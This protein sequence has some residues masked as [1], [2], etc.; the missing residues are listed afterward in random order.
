[1]N[2]EEE[3][4]NAL[5]GAILHVLPNC[6]S[7]LLFHQELMKKGIILTLSEDDQEVV[8]KNRYK[9]FL[10]HDGKGGPISSRELGAEFM[11]SSIVEKIEENVQA[12]KDREAIEKCKKAYEITIASTFAQ[13]HGNVTEVS[14]HL[15][16]LKPS[17]IEVICRSLGQQHGAIGI[18]YIQK[19]LQADINKSEFELAADRNRLQKEGYDVGKRPGNTLK[20]N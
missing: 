11:A 9:V 5:R 2:I 7:H 3:R 1:V 20:Y 14:K 8:G 19:R 13:H 17:E 4:K 15:K 16:S 10:F 12:E 6:T 18:A